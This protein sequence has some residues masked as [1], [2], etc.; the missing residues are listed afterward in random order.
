MSEQNPDVEDLQDRDDLTFCET[1]A[2]HIKDVVGGEAY[3][4]DTFF[5]KVENGDYTEVWGMH[6]IIPYFYKAV[7]RIL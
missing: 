2:D 4:Y 1:D 6:G 5:V 7:T 3:D